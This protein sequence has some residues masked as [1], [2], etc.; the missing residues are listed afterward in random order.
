[1]SA[2]ERDR[3]T[4]IGVSTDYRFVKDDIVVVI[5]KVENVKS[6]ER[7]MAE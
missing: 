7:D 3:S 4:D 5:G 6:F 2:I 1:M